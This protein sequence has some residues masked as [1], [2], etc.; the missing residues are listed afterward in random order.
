MAAVP[1]VAP[2]NSLPLQPI[3][4]V[5]PSRN[6]LTAEQRLVDYIARFQ[7][8]GLASG[9]HLANPAALGGEA[10]KALNGYFERATAL[11]EGAARKAQAMSDDR[12]QL[13]TVQDGAEQ[14]AQLPGGPASDRLETISSVEAVSAEPKVTGITEAELDRTVEALMAVMGYSVETSMITTAAN[15]ISKSSSTLIRGQ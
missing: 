10:L 2:N 15:N 6:T 8:E 13:T 5:G 4:P 12:N 7:A 1:P 14:V 3:D 9:K 11:Q